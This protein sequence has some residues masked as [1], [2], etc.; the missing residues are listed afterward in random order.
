M[1]GHGAGS[2]RWLVSYS[3][4]IT[5]LMAL[6]I[7]LF[8][9]GNIDIQKYKA[10]A[11][12]LKAALGGG[13][14]PVTVVNPGITSQGGLSPAAENSVPSPITIPGIPSRSLTG[15]DVAIQLST[16]L[17]KV[18]LG[19]AIS[20]QN[21]I[22]GTFLS[23][24]E[25]IKFEPGTATLTPG[26]NRTLDRMVPLIKPMTNQIRIVGHT[27]NSAPTDGRFQ[28][29]WELSMGRAL[30]V[31]DHLQKAG[32]PGHRLIASGHGQYEPLFPND[33][34]Q[35]RTMNSRVEIMIIYKVEEDVLNLQGGPA[36]R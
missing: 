14:G 28:N 11:E 19:D 32:I 5:V 30:A 8:A 24:S 33:T 36:L 1:A 15:E 22:E 34:P 3:D 29:N 35:H 4:F 2:E 7:I 18:N 12:S 21:N 17:S 13:G 6:F 10:L 27:D 26:A 23:L 9:M 31:V 25:Q 20:V 16:A